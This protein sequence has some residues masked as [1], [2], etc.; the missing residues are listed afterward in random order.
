MWD[1]VV[2]LL[3]SVLPEVL[4]KKENFSSMVCPACVDS[5]IFT[6]LRDPVTTITILFPSGLSSMAKA[7]FSSIRQGESSCSG[8]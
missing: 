6:P 7:V 1:Q 3:L 4:W 2:F 5:T 8:Y